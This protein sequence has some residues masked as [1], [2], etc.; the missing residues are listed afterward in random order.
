MESSSSVS[1]RLIDGEKI[2]SQFKVVDTVSSEVWN[3]AQ[4]HE[5]AHWNG[6]KDGDDWNNWWKEKFDNYSFLNNEKETNTVLEIGCGPWAKNLEFVLG[7]INNIPQ[8]IILEDPLLQEYLNQGM[9]VTRYQNFNAGT[10][11]RMISK[12]FEECDGQIIEPGSV[13]IALCNNVLD[14]VY[15][16]AKI[17]DNIYNCLKVGGV[18]VFGQD[19]KNETDKMVYDPMHPIMLDH[20]YIDQKLEGRYNSMF[21]KILSREEGRN[22]PYHYGTYLYAGRKL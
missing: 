20:E 15:D 11:T 9:S 16:A 8:N 19:L 13:D 18:F 21:K 4:A 22:P 14:H 10:T 5:S 6:M 3:N 7:A 2:M 1:I 17:F 12:P